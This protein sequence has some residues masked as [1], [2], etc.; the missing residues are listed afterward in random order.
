MPPPLLF[1]F[2]LVLHC[3]SCHFVCTQFHNNNI[4]IHD[5]TLL[6]QGAFLAPDSHSWNRPNSRG[7]FCDYSSILAALERWNVASFPSHTSRMTSAPTPLFPERPGGPAWNATHTPHA[8]PALTYLNS[9]HPHSVSPSCSVLTSVSGALLIQLRMSALPSAARG[10]GCESLSQL[11]RI[12]YVTLL[13][14]YIQPYRSSCSRSL[15]GQKR[16]LCSC[17]AFS[18]LLCSHYRSFR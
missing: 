8:T 15:R 7:S 16:Q 4:V 6:F 17:W 14:V 12:S 13:S 2:N 10:S 9:Q 3:C 1:F 5:N 18:A 11:Q